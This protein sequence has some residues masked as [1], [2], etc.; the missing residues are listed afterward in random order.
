[1]SVDI[2][3][4]NQRIGVRRQVTEGVDPI[5]NG[6]DAFYELGIYTTSWGKFPVV[7]SNIK[8]FWRGLNFN[9]YHIKVSGTKVVG[10]VSFI[11]VNGL[12]I[13]Y[14]MSQGSN[15]ISEAG[16]VFTIT[17]INKGFLDVFVIRYRSDNDQNRIQRSA[18][19]CKFVTLTFSIE[20]DLPNQP[21]A[22][23]LGYIGSQVRAIQAST[24]DALPIQPTG[25]STNEFFVDQGTFRFDW[26][27]TL[28][29]NGVYSSAGTDLTPYL[30]LISCTI[31]IDTRTFKPTSQHFPKRIVN[32]IRIVT[33]AFKL[34]RTDETS[35]FDDYHGT[36]VD[37]TTPNDDSQAGV[38]YALGSA[39]KPISFKIN[40]EDANYI[41][42]DLT[43]VAVVKMELNDADPEKEEEPWYDIICTSK[44]PV[45]STKDGVLNALYGL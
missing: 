24:T 45:F 8:Q 19:D 1:M 32:A 23:L 2:P 20:P 6:D 26:D 30:K 4:F 40:N 41:Q 39:F 11:P 12:P 14:I 42:M 29:G 33:L 22:M 35:F 16:G 13:A 7:E 31:D 17:G 3:Q 28:D 5:V 27:S 18:I 38:S 34:R 15:G 21:M 36:T 37:G 44:K 10:A 25:S 43:D 9:P